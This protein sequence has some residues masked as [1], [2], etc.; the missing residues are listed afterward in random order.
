MLCELLD[1]SADFTRPAVRHILEVAAEISAELLVRR[2]VE[3][4]ERGTI[5]APVV[6][7]NLASAQLRD[8]GL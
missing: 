5:D 7:E 2:E 8:D 3:T 6:L 4:I 1:L